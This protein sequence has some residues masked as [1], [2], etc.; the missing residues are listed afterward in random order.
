[1]KIANF[2]IPQYKTL[3]LYDAQMQKQFQCIEKKEKP[4]Q[5]KSKEKKETQKQDADEEGE[6]KKGKKVGKKRGVGI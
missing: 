6:A 2:D 5:D 4:D 3:D 1:M